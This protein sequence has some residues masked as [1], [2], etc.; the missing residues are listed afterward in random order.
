MFDA[1]ETSAAVI[2]SKAMGQIHMV[3]VKLPGNDLRVERIR[4]RRIRAERRKR[5]RMRVSAG[6][7]VRLRHTGTDALLIHDRPLQRRAGGV[8]R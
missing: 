6:K 8:G 4:N 7:E 5:E 2:E 1:V 3:P